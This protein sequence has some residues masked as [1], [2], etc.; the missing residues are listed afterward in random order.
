LINDI[1]DYS[2]I[3]AGKMN[4]ER[5]PFQLR[6]LIEDC[7]ELFSKQVADKQLEINYYMGVDVPARL[8]GDATRIRQ[9]INNLIGNAVKFTHQG[10]V[11][12]DVSLATI[13][14]LT[15]RCTLNISIQD[16]G[17]GI[18]AENQNGLF[19]AF[20]QADSSITRRFGGTGLGL[21]ICKKIVEQ[22]EGDIWF[23]SA[24]G[25]GTTFYVNLPLNFDLDQVDENYT[26][27]IATLKGLR[28]LIVDDNAT[29]RKVLA[30][31]LMQWEIIPVAFDSPDNALENL[32]LGN[33]Y[34][35]VLLDF[36]MPNS[37]GAN[38]ATKIKQMPCMHNKPI[39]LLSGAN[40]AKSDLDS[41]DVCLLKPVRNSILKKTI[42]QVLGHSGTSK[43]IKPK[44]VELAPSKN[45]KILVVEDNAVNQ[46]VIAMMLKKLGYHNFSLVADGE[47][48]VEQCKKINFD[49]I[50][51]D[52]QMV[53][54]DGYTAAQLIRQHTQSSMQPW[55]IALTA[56]AQREDSEKAFSAGMNSF[57][58]KPIQLDGLK[59]VLAVAEDAISQQL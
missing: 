41:I 58:T 11:F 23:K 6:L 36:C 33:E 28:V 47:E 40:T 53:R 54:M 50:F 25:K 8:I 1:L 22:M 31:T 35:L 3:E 43:I 42:S 37:N 16:T 57:T 17:I 38:I 14:K 2:K 27:E 32:S 49:I 44:V 51:M 21:V 10:E 12:V 39:V 46:M 7:I 56:G 4:L 59:S 30:N 55:I 34:D 48:A 19:N 26:K 13:D 5:S 24:E 52:I 9:I 29:N 45:T 18:S 20:S 15:N